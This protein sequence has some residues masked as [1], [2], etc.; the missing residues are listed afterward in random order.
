MSTKM[1]ERAFT[2]FIDKILVG[3]DY[4]RCKQGVG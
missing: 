4:H 1:D 3:D 2:R